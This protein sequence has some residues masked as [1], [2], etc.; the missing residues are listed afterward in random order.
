MDI[1]A[2]VLKYQILIAEHPGNVGALLYG[3]ATEFMEAY[4]T[5]IIESIHTEK[6]V[7]PE[8]DPKAL[9]EPIP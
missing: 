9:L 6:Q 8:S 5:K 2:L 4:T 7:T 3:F 1:G